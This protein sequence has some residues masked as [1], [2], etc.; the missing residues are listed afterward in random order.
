MLPVDVLRIPFENIEGALFLE[1][2][3]RDFRQRDT[4]GLLIFDTGA[5]YVALDRRLAQAMGLA[6]SNTTIMG[7]APRPLPRLRAGDLQQDAVGPILAIET[8][9]IESATDRAVFG[10]L[11][12]QPLASFAVQVDYRTDTLALLPMRRDGLVATRPRRLGAVDMAA[13]TAATEMAMRASR[14]QLGSL[15]APG[16][17][18]L[19]FEL[20]GDGKILIH[21]ALSGSA[22]ARAESSLTLILDTGATKTV[23]FESAFL[24]ARADRTWKE[25]HGLSA[26]TL[27]GLEETYL[28][29]VPSLALGRSGSR[30]E[31]TDVDVAVMRG[32]LE[33]TLGQAVGRRVDGLL[34]YSFLRR[35]R[36]TLDYPHRVLWL[37]PVDVPRDQRPNE[38]THVGLQVER[39]DGV[40]RVAAV[41]DRS[42]AAS[43][44]IRAGDEFVSIEGTPAER[45]DVVALTRRME[46]PAGSV[47][48]L[49][50][51][52]GPAERDY[53]LVRRRLL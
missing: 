37:E 13:A 53:R 6:D 42:P 30:I 20:E 34:G 38:Y 12:Q 43:A 39:R 47:V 45:L 15:L 49:R 5:G 52:R 1:T 32:P 28:A 14:D 2:T 23:L 26:P 44:G 29:R 16:A 31:A 17:I 9:V 27:Y 33:T 21:A 7:F 8:G 51:R 46:G 36:V 3:L 10:L 48:L 25:L 35:F 40:L 24:R 22:G 50:L 18:G 19:P 11:G 4:T 41:A